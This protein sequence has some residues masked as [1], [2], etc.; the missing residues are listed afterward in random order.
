M[1]GILVGLGRHSRGWFKSCAAHAEVEL[2][3]FVAR[4]E[5]TR[6]R[7]AAEFNLARQEFF[8]SLPEAAGACRVDFV[9]DV[10]PP[11]AHR[12]IALAAFA[13]GLHLLQEKPMCPSLDEA[14][15]VV[16]AGQAAGLRHMVA[17]NFRF[18]PLPRTTRRL[19]S[20][21]AIGQP[22]HLDVSFFVPWADRPGTHYVTQPYMFLADMC[23]HHFDM[24]RYVLGADP[25]AVQTLSWNQPWGWHQGDACHVASFDF[26]GLKAI[27][28]GMGCSLGH[29]TSC[30]GNWRIE[31][32]EGSLTWEDDRIFISR[33]HRTEHKRRQEIPH[34]AL[35]AAGQQAM[36]DEFLAAIR[37]N[38]Q[39]ECAATDNLHTLAM[40]LAAVQSAQTG[41]KVSIGRRP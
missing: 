31:G 38:R 41:R 22:G 17:Q 28:L 6:A 14:A 3:G 9:L 32:P 39:P 16:Q 15:E 37:Q 4:G 40:T 24:I 20:E 23:V 5:D 1:K 21:G 33:E 2:V 29:Q 10:T 18:G 26:P 8:S 12:Q 11:A 25:L 35:P 27:H 34:D 30:H 19:L 7:F 13:A 36:L